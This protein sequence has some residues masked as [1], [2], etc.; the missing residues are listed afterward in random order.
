M[1]VRV[2]GYFRV[3]ELGRLWGIKTIFVLFLEAGDDLVSKVHFAQIEFLHLTL[4]HFH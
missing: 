3:S 1:R 4:F 2:G